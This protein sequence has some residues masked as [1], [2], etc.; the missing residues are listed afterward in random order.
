MLYIVLLYLN[1]CE[2]LQFNFVSGVRYHNVS[3]KQLEEIYTIH[4]QEV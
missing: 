3:N 1:E 4:G 2:N